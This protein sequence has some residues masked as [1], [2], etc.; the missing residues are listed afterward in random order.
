MEIQIK[1]AI[2]KDVDKE[3]L[4]LFIEGYRYHQKGRPDI[5]SNKNN[6]TLKELM[7]DIMNNSKI[8][9]ALVDNKIVGYLSYK[10]EQKQS[11]KLNVDQI[12]ITESYRR[13]SIGK[14]LM[15]EAE[16]IA[17]KAR[18]DRIELSCWTFNTDALSVYKHL[19][20]DEQRIIYEKKI[21]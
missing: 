19:G 20:Y 2:K 5:F 21:K 9:I 13:K 7:D 1:E 11:K 3:L 12:I 15:N 6:E 14:T 17:K 16:K 18:C 8:I 10:I 4:E